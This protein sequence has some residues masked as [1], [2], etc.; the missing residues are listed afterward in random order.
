MLLAGDIGGTKTKLAIFSEEQG[1][2]EPLAEGTFLSK[3]YTGLASIAREFLAEVDVEVDQAS[4]GV[5]G[6]VIDNHVEV[7]NLPWIVDGDDLGRELGLSSVRLLNDLA[8]IANGVPFLRP[9]ELYTLY[10]GIQDPTGAIAVVA[11]GTGLGQA[12]LTWDPHERRYRPH[13]SE[14]GHTDFAPRTPDQVELLC[15]LWKRYS[16]VSNELVCSG[17]GI[18]NLYAYYRDCSDLEEPAWLAEQL[19]G[20]DDP[21]PIIVNAAQDEA[22]GCEL[23]RRTLDTFVSILGADAGNMALKVLATGG[24]YLGGGIPPRIL[25][26]LEQDRFL[27]A[28]QGKDRQRDLMERIPVHVILEPEVALIG[29]ACFGLG[30]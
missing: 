16:H 18:P 9:D 20:A 17:L 22:R 23:C 1:P 7:T 2:R 30:L 15:Y 5:A 10:E 4:F 27:E 6:P 26:A 13:P 28:L 3:E 11:P 12:Y 19:A 29:A 14:G 21:T 24:V 25:P 8:S